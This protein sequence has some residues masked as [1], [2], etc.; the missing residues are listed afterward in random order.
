[1]TE[2]DLPTIDVRTL[3]RGSCRDTLLCAIGELEVGGALIV[4]NDH[5]IQP[6]RA[7]VS[8]S[9]PGQ[10]TFAYLEDGPDVWRVHIARKG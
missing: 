8:L 10:F 5:D 7:A 1:M 6:L 4:V 3:P 9:R 2:A